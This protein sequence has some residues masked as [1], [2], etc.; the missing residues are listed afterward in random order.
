MSYTFAVVYLLD[1]RVR[2]W[3]CTLMTRTHACSS[4]ILFLFQ[5]KISIDVLSELLTTVNFAAFCLLTAVL[6]LNVILP[7]HHWNG[8]HLFSYKAFK[9]D[10][11]ICSVLLI[12][13]SKYVSCVLSLSFSSPLLLK[14]INNLLQNFTILYKYQLP[15]TVGET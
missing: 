6:C 7:Q 8:R 2:K 15:G 9:M 13:K 1:E 4:F 3:V 14:Y 12:L 11:F 5:Y 10:G